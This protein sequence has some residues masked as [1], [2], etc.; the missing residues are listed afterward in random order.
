MYTLVYESMYVCVCVCV[1]VL[2][3]YVYIYER[4]S[5]FLCAYVCFLN[6]YMCVSVWVGMCISMGICISVIYIF[7]LVC[8]ITKEIIWYII[9]ILH[10]EIN[11]YITYQE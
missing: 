10:Q 7:M 11:N 4:K 6:V 8:D 1:C 5:A 3:M 2:F 9:F